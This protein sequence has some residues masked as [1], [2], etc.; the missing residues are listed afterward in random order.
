MRRST[1]A[2]LESILAFVSSC[3]DVPRWT[4]A[5][6]RTFAAGGITGEAGRLL[7]LAQAGNGEL[8]GLLAATLVAGCAELEAIVVARSAR[9]QG[10][11]RG[12]IQEWLLW[13]ESG[14]G[15]D[16][17]LEVRARNTPA[18]ALYRSLGFAV[19]GRRRDYY[20]DPL[21]DA[22][23]MGRQLCRS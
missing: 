10:V 21:E 11:G 13:A 23:L 9:R 12:L 17:V 22:I 1:S 15:M 14:G 6:W 18:L 16:A 5:A 20:H 4:E 3:Q 19:Q 7:L 2:D 8:C